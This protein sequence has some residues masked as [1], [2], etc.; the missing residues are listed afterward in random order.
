[1]NDSFPCICNHAKRYHKCDHPTS[2]M[3]CLLCWDILCLKPHKLINVDYMYHKFVPDN[4]GYLESKSLE[5]E[6]LTNN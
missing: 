4:L 2:G 5:K 1:M 6:V 3:Y